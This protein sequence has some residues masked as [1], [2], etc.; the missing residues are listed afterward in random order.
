MGPPTKSLAVGI[1]LGGTRFRIALLHPGGRIVRRRTGATGP[2]RRPEDVIDELIGAVRTE[3]ARSKGTASCVGIG[4]AAQVDRAGRIRLAPNLGWR[5]VPLVGPFA[6]AFRVPVVALN[7]V[8]AATVGEWRRGAGR[9]ERDLVTLFIGTGLGGGVVSDGH[10]LTGASNSAGE[11][12]HLTLV[13]GGRRCTCSRA[14][15][16]EAYVSGWAIEAR[17]REAYAVRPAPRGRA[18]PVS[19]SEVIHAGIAGDPVAHQLLEET[20]DHLSAGL[21]GIAN[22]FNPRLVIGGGGVVEGYPP[23]L[24]EAVRRARPFMLPTAGEVLEYRP[25][26]LGEFAVALGAA[27]VAAEALP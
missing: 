27:T 12:G 23:L 18:P 11:L 26:S 2:G 1:D 7:D 17:A 13:E 25:A 6:E 24:T 21:V 19:A 8:R 14:G 20:I 10:L 15:C 4:V 9:G 5:E 3:L 16:L 22:A